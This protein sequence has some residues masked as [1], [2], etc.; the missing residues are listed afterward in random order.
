M[1]L[2]ITDDLVNPLKQVSESESKISDKLPLRVVL[3]DDHALV[4]AGI[5]ALLER[6]D[7]VEVLA[8]AGDGRQALELIRNLRPDV[9]LLDIAM[10]LLSGMEVLREATTTF[11]GVKIIILTVHE[12]EEYATHAIQFG[13]VGFLPKSSASDELELALRTVARGERYLSAGSAKQDQYPVPGPP[14]MEL[15]PRQREVL[16]MIAK[17][18]STKDIARSLLISVKTVETHRAQL[19]E[20]LQI[21]DVA[22]LVRYAIRLGLVKIDE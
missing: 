14:I 20:R 12:T 16:V 21:Y 18:Q 11:P 19:M 8:E 6:M 1:A 9:V 10:P 7:G 13:A 17:G 15:T 22:G 4:R 5:R 2:K 3:V